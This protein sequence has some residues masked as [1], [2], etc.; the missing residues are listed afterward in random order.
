MNWGI[1]IKLTLTS[2]SAAIGAKLAARLDDQ[3]PSS[4]STAAR[5]EALQ[6]A[7]QMIE[8]RLSDAKLSILLRF[9]S[10]FCPQAPAIDLAERTITLRIRTGTFDTRS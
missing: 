7:K 9:C 4:A 6:N 2:N 5:Q 8:A 3:R 1:E 10:W